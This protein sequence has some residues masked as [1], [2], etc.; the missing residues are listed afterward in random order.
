MI[1]VP[2]DTSVSLPF[3]HHTFI[4][5][6]QQPRWTHVS[7]L[8]PAFFQSKSDI[9]NEQHQCFPTVCK[10]MFKFLISIFPSWDSFIPRGY[11][12]MSE[13]ILVVE[14][15]EETSGIYWEIGTRDAAK[16]AT[17]HSIILQQRIICHKMSLELW[18][19]NPAFAW[20]RKLFHIW[21]CPSFPTHLLL[22]H[23]KHL[24]SGHKGLLDC[25]NATAN[26]W[27]F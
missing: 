22:F 24:C 23:P 10:V 21:S 7:S 20:H 13:A 19:K 18:L 6:L 5:L 1:S 26:I 15:G 12:I 3:S 9:L 16:Y 27:Q 8:F 2:L 11:L 4:C 25:T 17:R 14:P